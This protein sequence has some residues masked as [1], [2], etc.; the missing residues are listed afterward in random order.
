D[1]AEL[2]DAHEPAED[3]VVTDLHVAGQRGV[4]GEHAVAA[5]DAVVGDVGIGEQPVF[6]ADAGDPAAAAG[7]AVDGGELADDVAVAD[8]QPHGLAAVLLG[9]RVA[10]DGGVGVHH[11]LA[12]AAGGAVDAAVRPYA[13]AVSDLPAGADARERADVAPAAK[14]GRRIDHRGGM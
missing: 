12:A 7:A 3:H 2:V 6:V 1:A 10:A 13:G 14:P 5:D 11:V 4:V 8:F 9:V